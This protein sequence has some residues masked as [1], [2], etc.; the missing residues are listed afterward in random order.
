[1]LNRQFTTTVAIPQGQNWVQVSD[2][3]IPFAPSDASGVTESGA[4]GT[5]IW[6]TADKTTITPSGALFNLSGA[7]TTPNQ[8]LH[9]TFYGYVPDTQDHKPTPRP[10][11]PTRKPAVIPA[12]QQPRG[13]TISLEDVRQFSFDRVAS[14]NPLD[15][16][17]SFT[18]HDLEF[19]MRFTA[20][21]YNAI[22]PHVIHVHPDRLPFGE[23][24]L[25]GIMYY[26]YTGKLQQLMRNDVDYSAGNMSIDINK[27]RIES[28]QKLLP[29]FKE[30]FERQAKEEKVTINLNNGFADVGGSGW[31]G[32]WGY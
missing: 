15:L 6:A 14:D 24:M 17:L 2:L 18:E 26:L 31:G 19:A 12:R 22:P 1:M 10:I 5:V 30:A 32:G 23:T 25:N 16:D 20:M 21:R 29:M 11:A 4:D 28:L 13:T 7:P 9:V 8:T 3:S 27:R